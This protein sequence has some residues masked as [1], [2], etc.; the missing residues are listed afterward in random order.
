MGNMN[1]EQPDQ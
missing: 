1:L